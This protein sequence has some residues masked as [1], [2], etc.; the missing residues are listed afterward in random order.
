MDVNATPI[1]LQK[2]DHSSAAIL[3]Q[4]R[5]NMSFNNGISQSDIMNNVTRTLLNNPTTV[6]VI[7]RANFDEVIETLNNKKK[8]RQIF[9][10]DKVTKENQDKLRKTFCM[11]NLDF[12]K[13]T[14]ESGHPFW[15]AHRRLSEQKM[16]ASLGIR[17]SSKPT[18]AYDA[19]Y[20]DVGGN[21]TTHLSR[22]ELF[23]H[24]CAPLLS[25]NDDKRASAYKHA[26]RRTSPRLSSAC[27]SLHL[28][29]NSRVICNRKAQNC[30]IKT[31][32]LIF[33]HSTYDMSPL[34]IADSME[35]AN[36]LSAAGCFHFDTVILY[37]NEGHISNGLY[38]KKFLRNDRIRIRFWFENDN[39]EG[40]E[41]DYINYINLIRSTRIVSSSGKSTYN[42]SFETTEDSV[43]YFK[44][45]KSINGN[46]PEDRPFRV[47]SDP[48][49]TDKSI[50]YYWSWD[51]IACGSTSDKMK[52]IRLVA[53]KK[54]I[55]KMISYADTLPESKFT[56][57]NIHVAATSFNTR[58]VINGQ[59]IGVVESIK[60]EDLKHLSHLVFLMV[61]ISNYETSKTL[62]TLIN[63]E[64]RSRVNASKNKFMRFFTKTHYTTRN[65]DEMNFNN[66]VDEKDDALTIETKNRF[67]QFLTFIRDRM[68]VTRKYDHSI[69]D[70]LV[71]FFTVEE[72]L[73]MLIAE[74]EKHNRGFISDTVA[75]EALDYSAVKEAC[76]ESLE[77]LKSDEKLYS[78]N[79]YKNTACVSELT[80]VPNP[81]KGNCVFDSIADAMKIE[82]DNKK[83]RNRLYSSIYLTRLSQPAKQRKILLTL[84]GSRS[85]WGDLETFI[86]FSLEFQQ[87]VC[88]HVD[89]MC[90]RFGDAPYKHFLIENNHCTF[91]TPS[92][93]LEPIPKFNFDNE[94]NVLEYDTSSRDALYEN[95]FAS[96]D[97]LSKSA[98]TKRLNLARYNYYALSELGNGGY[99]CR[100]GLKTAEMFQRFFD[101]EIDSAV[102]IG[103]PGGEA[104]FFCERGIH[105]FGIT[106]IDKV[107]F[108]PLVNPHYFNF[109]QLLGNTNDG[110]ITRPQNIIDFR[111]TILK[112][113]PSG[114][115]FFGG[116]VADSRDFENP[117]ELESHSNLLAWEVLLC[118]NV[119]RNN[120]QA[121][122]K[123]FD[124]L[125]GSTSNII[126]FLQTV[127]SIVEIVKLETSRPASTELHV[128][129]R[130]FTRRNET[131]GIFYRCLNSSDFSQFE[132]PWALT[133]QKYF[134]GFSVAGLTLLKRAFHSIGVRE[135]TNKLDPERLESYRNLLCRDNTNDAGSL[136]NKVKR[137]FTKIVSEFASAKRDFQREF[138]DFEY[139]VDDDFEEFDDL[140]VTTYATA[141]LPVVTPTPEPVANMKKNKKNFLSSMKKVFKKNTKK[142]KRPDTTEIGQTNPTGITQYPIVDTVPHTIAVKPVRVPIECVADNI[143]E[144]DECESTLPVS[145][146]AAASTIADSMNEFLELTKFTLQSQISNHQRFLS[147]ATILPAAN[148]FAILEN[149]NYSL[150]KVISSGEEFNFVFVLKNKPKKLDEYNKFFFSGQFHKIADIESVLSV[151]DIFVLSEYCELAIEPEMIEACERIDV[152]SFAPPPMS[153]VQ[154]AP[155]T[156]KTTFIVNNSI[157]PHVLGASNILISTKE[158]KNDFIKR[159]ETKYQITLSKTQR[160]HIRTIASFLI[161]SSKNIPSDLL[162]VDEAFMPHPGQIFFAAAISGA[163]EVKLLGD[164]LQI[165]YVNRTP[166][167]HTKHDDLLKYVTVSEFLH[168]SYR[169]PTDV[170]A[171]LNSHYLKFN[172]ANGKAVGMQSTRLAL[173]TCKYVQLTNDN[174]PK[175]K[176]IQYLTFTQAEKQKLENFGLKVSTV[177]EYQG[178]EAKNIRVVR[179]NA[180][181]QEEIF[182]RFNYA[183]VALTRHTESLEY[184][185]RVTSDALSKLIGV[186]GITN[187]T[188]TSE[189]TIRASHYVNA[190]GLEHEVMTYFEDSPVMDV[191]TINVINAPMRKIHGA[192]LYFVPQFGYKEEVPFKPYVMTSP[193][194]VTRYKGN[195]VIFVVS[196]QSYKQNYSITT[197]RKNLVQLRSVIN[198]YEISHLF[199]HGAAEKDIARATLGYIL[200]KH[201]PVKLSLVS[202][203]PCTGVPDEVFQ[204]LNFNCLNEIPNA[205]RK[206]VTYEDADVYEPFNCFAPEFNLS[207]AQEFIN[208]IFG[209]CAYVDQQFDSWM[210][211]NS[212]LIMEI[213]DVTFSSI[214][215]VS[216]PKTYDTMRPALRTPM[217]FIRNYDRREIL[218]ALEKRNRNVPF[219]NGTVDFDVCSSEMLQKLLHE[220]FD[221]VKLARNNR[222]PIRI[223]RNEV[224]Q[225]LSNQPTDTAKKILPEFA[226]H[227]TA[228]N[229]YNFSIKRKPKPALT[230]DAADS[231]LA[232]QTIVYHEKPINAIFCS[233]W[234]EIKKRVVT[235]L[236]NHVKLFCDMSPS[237]FEKELDRDVPS[238]TLSSLLEKL[239]IDISKYDKSQRELAL[240]FECKLM[241]FFGVDEY[242][243]SLWFNAHVLS[244]IYDK[245]SKLKCL[246]PYQRKSGDASTFIGNTLFLMAVICDFIPV[247]L[248][249][250]ALFSGDDS[251]LYGFDLSKYKNTQH[252]GLK[253]NLEIKFFNY[254]FSYFCSKFLLPVDG[255]WK[256]TPDPV[257][258]FTKIGRHDLVNPAHV[259]EYRISC[260]DNLSNYNSSAICA[261]VASAVKERYGIYKDFTGFFTSIPSMCKRDTFHSLFYSEHTDRIDHTITFNNNFD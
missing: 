161:N 162:Y 258:F 195:T 142:G 84:D 94:E 156:G 250:L 19:V 40:Y 2:V 176:E 77:E 13:A 70:S 234:R 223:S 55:Q 35:A 238:H 140:S 147:H 226:L 33:L 252:F 219:M 167:F 96:K 32:C 154:A 82:R 133:A 64:E 98:F 103:G 211:N 51:S 14:N 1:D 12:S 248:L 217:P 21:P 246:I 201:L 29:G 244:M 23:V 203:L 120:G 123:I 17:T 173:N 151:G 66:L 179:L 236:K 241:R 163:K 117:N 28:E 172:T 124:I 46:V 47:F 169:C 102:T 97:E 182:L 178:K 132:A 16:L 42:I 75:A 38:F 145:T 144:V 237:D 112:K 168:I 37:T 122:F 118:L 25:N 101:I 220:C 62:S 7:T 105:T 253:F 11:F 26:M 36:A 155:G 79:D 146:P 197:I 9:V 231:Y 184:Y 30:N 215:G 139:A 93:N 206:T 204:L 232:L 108:H 260:I 177:H 221:P 187:F 34:D 126:S 91:L 134:D 76:Y 180:F 87:S 150:C 8:L 164:A 191:S 4:L 65:F 92:H 224:T 61:Y 41:H 39:Q 111:D 90:K 213:G 56:V 170:A 119:L 229:S 74:S 158:G 85:G 149:G 68:S 193:Y 3:D 228:V 27:L 199:V 190:G 72:E 152:S 67:S 89:G 45:F 60:P 257:K 104:Q 198:D 230:V 71:Q 153:L 137:Q 189:D 235:S 225:W 43:T 109:R 73:K 210:L 175:D 160:N 80:S 166:A 209:P 212:D 216:L 57:K 181:K 148:S 114:I 214:A 86:L 54:L 171:R 78:L 218:T 20:K 15:R 136:I 165:P 202:E 222:D 192:K 121:Y 63:D 116:D 18:A 259:E 254:E 83:I 200:K 50:V 88:V 141:E 48:K 100:S 159:I 208:S 110:D 106:H 44:I 138:D 205:E 129:C 239:E 49:L 22:G 143:E 115:E 157:P 53:P 245:T 130:G 233:I 185:T 240:E 242:F 247:S 99:V 243:I 95:F 128:V 256:F 174:F 125:D 31:E 207:L 69:C 24:T 249:K 255:K 196:S 6:D 186:D 59:S 10:Y 251:L 183:L 113:Y 127:F 261:S 58:E 52:K 131:V 194:M 188:F 107:D 227:Q 81:G 135:F 5:Q